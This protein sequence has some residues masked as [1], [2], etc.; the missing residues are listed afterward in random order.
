MTLM[1]AP[2]VEIIYD[3]SVNSVSF[4][5]YPGPHKAYVIEHETR[6]GTHLTK[7]HTLDELKLLR[8]AIEFEEYLDAKYREDEDA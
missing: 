3:D 8:D 1:N 2:G 5:R 4:Y 6:Q 7:I